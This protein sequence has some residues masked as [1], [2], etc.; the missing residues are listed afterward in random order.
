MSDIEPASRERV[1][2]WE[3]P[4]IA[5]RE[6]RRRGL[7]GLAFLRAIQAGELPPPPIAVLMGMT[8]AA[9]DEGRVVFTVEPAEYHYNPIGVVH[10]GLAATLLDSAIGCAVQTLAPTGVAYT[11]I[12]LKVNYVR[13]LRSGMG[14]VM[15]EGTVLHFGRQIALA[16][17][18]VTDSAGKLYAHATS[19][20]LIMR[21]DSPSERA[22]GEVR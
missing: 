21:P 22:P 2:R 17:A 3:D 10:G 20:C 19:T 15:G 9:V 6:A 8:L 5:P 18:R 7:S 11:T 12:E 13:P 14:L 4:H 16:E 1:I